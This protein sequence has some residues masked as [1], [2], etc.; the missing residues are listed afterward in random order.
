MMDIRQ[1]AQL[2]VD[3]RTLRTEIS[4]IRNQSEREVVYVVPC[5]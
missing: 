4:V 2:F 1:A 5:S 3:L